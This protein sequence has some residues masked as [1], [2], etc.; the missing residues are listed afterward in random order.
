MVKMG[1]KRVSESVVLSVSGFIAIWMLCF[2]VLMF[3]MNF[4]GLDIE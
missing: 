4:S 1:G 2:V 3:A